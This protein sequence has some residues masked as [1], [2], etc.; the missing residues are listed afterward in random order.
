MATRVVSLA[1]LIQT[2]LP[3]PSLGGLLHGSN[4]HRSGVSTVRGHSIVA[5][6]FYLDNP[7][8]LRQ[9]P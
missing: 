3:W 2:M 8:Y 5:Y 7:H 9:N 4:N 6:P 1:V